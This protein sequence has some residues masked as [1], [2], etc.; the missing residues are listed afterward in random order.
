VSIFFQRGYATYSNYNIS[1]EHQRRQPNCAFFSLRF[2]NE[3]RSSS[4]ESVSDEM[5][6][7][8]N[9]SEI[10]DR[11][12]RKTKGNKALIS[13][14]KGTAK[15]GGRTNT[16]LSPEISVDEMLD[17]PIQSPLK[18]RRKRSINFIS[19]EPVILY[20]GRADSDLDD[21]QESSKKQKTSK[22]D[23]VHQSQHNG[24]GI[25]LPDNETLKPKFK[26]RI[27]SGRNK[28]RPIIV[29]EQDFDEALELGL[30]GFQSDEDQQSHPQP[31]IRT[32]QRANR[33]RTSLMVEKQMRDTPSDSLIP[34]TARGK[35]R[36][37][38]IDV[39]RM[40]IF[41]VSGQG[42]MPIEIPKHLN[43]D[44]TSEFLD[45]VLLDEDPE[46]IMDPTQKKRG[47]P[48]R[49]PA[50]AEKPITLPKRTK[51]VKRK[52]KQKQENPKIVDPLEFLSDD[53]LKELQASIKKRKDSQSISP[54]KFKMDIVSLTPTIPDE[55]LNK[56][57]RSQPV[58]LR[59]AEAIPLEEII[60]DDTVSE[61]GSVVH[62]DVSQ[63]SDAPADVEAAYD[64]RRQCI[65]SPLQKDLLDVV[66]HQLQ[67]PVTSDNISY[68][69]SEVQPIRGTRSSTRRRLTNQ[70]DFA[71]DEMA[72]TTA[73]QTLPNSEDPQHSVS[74]A[75]VSPP[76][77]HSRQIQL[78]IHSRLQSTPNKK[79]PHKL[80]DTS[81]LWIPI[82]LDTVFDAAVVEKELNL[83]FGSELTAAE[84][85]M[86]IEEW[87]KWS[88][89]KRERSFNRVAERMI[90]LFE[91]HG[92]KAALSI[93]GIIA[94]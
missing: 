33:S 51:A 86:T 25:S 17:E 40:P 34:T 49:V 61:S 44:R 52:G 36:H 48:R 18:P 60:N 85:E 59:K 24:H 42:L 20:D 87:I 75:L 39:G 41:G 16:V 29:T 68:D 90:A 35:G 58:L 91:E 45:G 47:R 5:V 70:H 3:N 67:S 80:V 23:V 57:I 21:S 10:Y 9:E 79:S 76:A 11:P 31:F 8:E 15:K 93:Q 71:N 12:S 53:P 54:Q 56:H 14:A 81:A 27:T 64:V 65:R 63:S 50:V 19:K 43:D 84:R 72:V 22:N 4:A 37:P 28:P 92:R 13:K 74:Q 62:H 1:N 2:R 89:A 88:A 46:R 78:S 38:P 7:S 83:D 77:A 6:I 73:D 26:R 55:I 69:T 82:D 30:E 66:H 94:D 32:V